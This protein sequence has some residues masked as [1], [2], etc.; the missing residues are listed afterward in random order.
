M[1]ADQARELLPLYAGD[2]LAAEE[3]AAVAAAIANDEALAAEAG[4]LERLDALL[5]EALAPAAAEDEAEEAP[6]WLAAALSADTDAGTGASSEE[7]P[8]TTDVQ[9]PPGLQEP[10]GASAAVTRRC[11][12]CHDGLASADER[13]LCAECATPHHAACF[14]EHGGCALRGC[15]SARSIDASEAAARQVCASCQGLSPAEA[16]F[17]AWCGETLVEARPGRVA[18]PLLTLRQYAMAAG[19]VLATSLGIGGYLGKGQEPMLRTLELQAKTI[20]KEELRRGLQQLSA[21]QVRFRAEDLDGDGQPDYALGLD[22][23]L[24]VSFEASPKGESRAWQLRRLLRDYTLTF[25]SKPEGGFEIHAAPR[26]DE[27]QWLGVGGLRVDESGEA[28]RSSESPQGAPR[29]AEDHE[30]EDHD[31]RD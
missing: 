18:S 10:Q 8:M 12:Y 19:L 6:A 20:R 13:V 9:D 27:A 17:C 11:P 3:R 14:S 29:H 2:D 21:L 22:E 26:A 30:E 24:S 16:P 1:N 4:E 31:E 5:G 25:S 23:L 7:E 15:E 28:S